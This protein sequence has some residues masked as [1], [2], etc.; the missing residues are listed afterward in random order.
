MKKTKLSII[1]SGLMIATVVIV[2]SCKKSTTTTTP[3]TTPD[4][5]TTST[6]DNNMAQQS[7]HD[8]T[9]M[10]SQAIDNGSLSTYRLAGGGLVSPQ[11]AS[12][13]IT[14]APGTKTLTITFT[15]YHG[16]DGNVRNGTLE[17]DWSASVSTSSYTATYFKDSGLVLSVTTPLND[18]SVNGNSIKINKKNYQKLR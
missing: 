6:T 5:S 3:T 10:G 17:Y 9:N 13:T 8:I 2:A 18:Y 7:A 16:L 12:V 4:T 1:L 11:S 15:N 14:H